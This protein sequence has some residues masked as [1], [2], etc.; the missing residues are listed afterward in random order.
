MEPVKAALHNY[1]CTGVFED[2]SGKNAVFFLDL[3]MISQKLPL[4]WVVGW[5]W[6]S[7]STSSLNSL[8]CGKFESTDQTF[9]KWTI[10][11]K[12]ATMVWVWCS[13]IIENITFI[14]YLSTSTGFYLVYT[15]GYFFRL[16]FIKMLC[17]L[18]I[19]EVQYLTLLHENH[20]QSYIL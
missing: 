13:L 5:E 16:L 7:T 6:S 20:Y 19:V 1:A 11:D 12:C 3:N 8:G 4:S 14:L 18:L 2:P 15:S 17:S 10:I 9:V